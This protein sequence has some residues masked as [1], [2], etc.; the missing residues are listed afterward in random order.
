LSFLNGLKY[1][2]KLQQHPGGELVYAGDR[3]FDVHGFK[4]TTWRDV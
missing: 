3:A 4:V 2:S 1:F